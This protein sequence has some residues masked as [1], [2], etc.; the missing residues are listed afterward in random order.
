[1]IGASVNRVL[2]PQDAIAYPEQVPKDL[3]HMG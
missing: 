1:M 2:R 3:R